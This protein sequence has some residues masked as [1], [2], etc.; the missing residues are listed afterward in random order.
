M[1][2]LRLITIPISHYCEKA[3][4][5]LQRSGLPFHEERH[6][7]L[8]HLWYSYKAGKSDSVPI[9]VT[10]N[11]VLTDSTDI[12]KWIDTQVKEELRLYPTDP[13]VKK[14]VED[15]E[16]S[17]DEGFGSAGRQ[18]MYTFLLDQNSIVHKYSEIHGVPK[19]ELKI[20]PII[21]PLMKGLIRK[22]LELTLNTRAESQQA[23]NEIF[24]DVA[25]RLSDGRN[26]LF[27][28]QFTAA[29]L[30]FAALSAAV[31]IPENYGV[32]LPGIEELPEEMRIQI[33]KWREHPAGKYALRIYQT[34]RHAKT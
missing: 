11:Q 17:L 7:Q 1:N 3:R 18:W 6:L 15:F 30:T 25:I 32:V 29:D 26:H 14:E 2:P 12:L 21:L 23:I 16:D 28:N 22:D 27:G 34:H 31:L 10:P 13:A 4:W 33:L 19:L 20:L 24:K 8:F 9:L 5:A